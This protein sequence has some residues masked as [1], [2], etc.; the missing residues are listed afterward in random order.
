MKSAKLFPKAKVLQDKILNIKNSF[1]NFK[2][3]FK[4]ISLTKIKSKLFN[5]NLFK[6]PLILAASAFL[7]K[8]QQ[9]KSL[10]QQTQYSKLYLSHNKS[11]L[12]ELKANQLEQ[13]YFGVEDEKQKILVIKKF[14]KFYAFNNE[15]PYQCNSLHKGVLIHSKIKCPMH[16]DTF[17][18]FTGENLIGP[19]LDDLKKYEL[20]I[21]ESNN[22]KNYYIEVEKNKKLRN[23][24]KTFKKDS[25][26]NN[27][28][29]IIGGG[30]AAVSCAKTLRENGFK[31]EITIYSEEKYL[32][33]NRPAIS[34]AFINDVNT[35]LLKDE[36]FYKDYDINIQL[37]TEVISLNE[38]SKEIKL[39]NG[40]VKVIK[41]HLNIYFFF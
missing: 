34:K 11:K 37:K 30:I 6:I 8:S 17:D 40:V 23:K 35:I 41:I 28:F 27:K 20:K 32:P 39:S 36:S 31:G 10:Y 21:E 3:N 9:K 1:S 19:A 18:L 38:K 5:R 7:I 14:G 29:I 13:F 22:G 16:G 26:D 25:Q 33:Y 12:E 24:N 4:S 2:S 15:C